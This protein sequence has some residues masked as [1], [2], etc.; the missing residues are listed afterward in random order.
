MGKDA[1]ALVH[2]LVIG[3]LDPVLHLGKKW[4]WKQEA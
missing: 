2:Q 3:V 4:G 1:L